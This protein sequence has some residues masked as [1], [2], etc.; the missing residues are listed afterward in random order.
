M[1][2]KFN[3]PKGQR[4]ESVGFVGLTTWCEYKWCK[5]T[6][7]WVSNE[8]CYLNDIDGDDYNYSIHSL[9]S[10]IRHINKHKHYLPKGVTFTLRSVYVGN[11]DID[12]II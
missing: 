4:I 10:A 2:I 9:K 1:K 12:I 3:R 8:Q 7:T 6:N 5:N 11:Y